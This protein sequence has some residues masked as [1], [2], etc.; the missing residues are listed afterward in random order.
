MNMKAWHISGAL[1]TLISGVL[2]HFAFQWS[3]ENPLVGFFSAVNESTWEHLKLIAIPALI[4]SLIEYIS[5][6]KRISSFIPSKA[7]SIVAGMMAIVIL[8]YGYT[9]IFGQNYLAADIA[10]FAIGVLI[11]YYVSFR[12]VNGDKLGSDISTALG[13][14]IIIAL[15]ICFALFTSAPPESALFRDPISGGYGIIR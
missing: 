5:Y 12:L 13:W 9:A 2:L 15:I 14:G 6:G 7:V 8:F 1:F 10:V 3:Q 11:M 4:F